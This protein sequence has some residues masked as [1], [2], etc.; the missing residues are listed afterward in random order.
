MSEREIGVMGPEEETTPLEKER[1]R[2]SDGNIWDTPP[3]ED[4]FKRMG[5][6]ISE[7]SGEAV[8]DWWEGIGGGFVWVL[9]LSD[10]STQHLIYDSGG[11]IVD[12]DHRECV[13]WRVE[14]YRNGLR[15]EASGYVHDWQPEE[16]A[17]MAMKWRDALTK[18]HRSQEVT[19]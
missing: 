11:G 18:L 14:A 15:L 13:K 1:S 17:H 3:T 19:P 16:A 7:D 9:T 4:D 10:E 12:V 6:L 8:Y 2:Y 5:S